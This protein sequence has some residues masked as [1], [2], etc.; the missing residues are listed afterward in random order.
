MLS[1]LFVILV[2]SFL[3]LFVRRFLVAKTRENSGIKA[4]RQEERD[5]QKGIIAMMVL[6]IITTLSIRLLLS[7]LDDH[8][9]VYTQTLFKY[10][11]ICIGKI[12][13]NA[14]SSNCFLACII[15]I[16]IFVIIIIIIHFIKLKYTHIAQ[17]HLYIWCVFFVPWNFLSW[18]LSTWW[19]SRVWS[20]WSTK[21]IL[22]T[23]TAIYYT[24]FLFYLHNPHTRP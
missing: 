11:H 15:I 8:I 3:S 20:S 1:L 21:K 7:S 2:S 19:S 18:S 6:S 23:F 14:F 5:R 24:R 9:I 13:W 10:V 22:Y 17:A 12:F 16:I 4:E